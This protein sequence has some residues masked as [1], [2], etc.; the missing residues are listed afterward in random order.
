MS[1]TERSTSLDPVGSGGDDTV[2]ACYAAGVASLQDGRL[3]EAGRWADRCAAAPGGTD[4]PRCATLAGR[5]AVEEGDFEEAARHL[6]RAWD[7]APD[8]TSVAR[9]LGEALTA[10]GEVRAAR[11]VLEDA[12]RRTA[13]DDVLVDLSYLCLLDRDRRGACE[14][15]ERAAA[16]RPDD[17]EVLLA[18]ARIYEALGEPTRAADVAARVARAA[19]APTVLTDLAR[20][21]LAAERFNEAEAT[22]RR[23]QEVDPEHAVFAQHGRIWC[24][25]RAGDWRGA[26]ELAIGAAR[27]DR[28]ELTTALLAYAKDRLFTRVPDHLAA[29]R[30]AMLGE[31]FMA[32]L[33]DH[34]EAHGDEG[35]AT[36]DRTEEEHGG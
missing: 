1:R 5:V 31:R 24:R 8:D 6:R 2:E 35:S 33:R 22:F 9:Q 4:D 13:N 17:H 30:E 21:L 28:F 20:L 14:A 25:I 16:L 34:A 19:T 3:A 12:A 11:A 32:E 26:L 15:I 7:L 27:A 10:G 23:L 29:A 18:Q 36:P